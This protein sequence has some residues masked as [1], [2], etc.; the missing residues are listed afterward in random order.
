MASIADIHAREVLDSRGSWTIEVTLTLETGKKAVTSVPQGK[1]KGMYEANSVEPKQAVENIHRIIKPNLIGYDVTHQAEIDQLLLYLDGTHNKSNLGGNTLLAVSMA[2]MEAGALCT[3]MPTWKY[4]RHKSTPFHMDTHKK[5][6]LY[7]NVING[8]QH[9]GNNLDFQEYLIIPT[10]TTI[11]ESVNIGVQMYQALK[12]HISETMGAEATALGDE[13]GFAP[14]FT[15]NEEPLKVI[16][17][18]AESE[19]LSQ[20]LQLGIDAA[21][22]EISKSTEELLPLYKKIVNTYNMYYLEDPFEE[23]DFDS[24]TLLCGDDVC[25][26]I[27]ICGD[28]LTV[29]NPARIELAHLHHSVNAVIIKPNQIGTITETLEAIHKARSWN[30]KVIVSHRSGETNEDFIADLAYGIQADG[31]KLGAPARGE[32]I[33]KYNRLMQIED[34]EDI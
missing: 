2:C 6:R 30:W 8:G 13:G 11:R 22:N 26:N 31:I 17:H 3:G 16:A 10:A 24:F 4:I 34:E 27:L 20:K 9:A 19:G 29:T 33:L 15:D 23:K 14:D 18:V 21:A 25:K 12:Q 32:R 5:P 1:S 28:D 7:I